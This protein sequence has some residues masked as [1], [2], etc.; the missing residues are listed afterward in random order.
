MGHLYTAFSNLVERERNLK[1]ILG[2][3]STYPIK[4]SSSVS[5]HLYYGQIIHLHD[6]LHVLGLK[7]NILS[8][9]SLEDKGMKVSFINGM[10]LTRPLEYLLRD[11]FTLGQELK[12]F[13]KLMEDQILRIGS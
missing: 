7:G 5:F 3:N 8:I 6:V 12:T 2:E 1:I 13:T 9:Y 10:V 4:G 11:A